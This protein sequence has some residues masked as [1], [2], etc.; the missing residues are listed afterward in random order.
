[1]GARGLTAPVLSYDEV[2]TSARPALVGV[3]PS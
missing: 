2:G 1:M 3:V